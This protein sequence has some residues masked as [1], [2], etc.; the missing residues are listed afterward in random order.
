MVRY[1]LRPMEGKLGR[2]LDSA[3]ETLRGERGKV[4][5]SPLADQF[6]AEE[7]SSC[8][9]INTTICPETCPLYDVDALSRLNV[10]PGFAGVASALSHCERRPSIDQITEA[11]AKLQMEAIGFLME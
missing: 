8:M 11:T 2:F 9:V 3:R 7:N 6:L 10:Q 4:Y 5:R 1:I